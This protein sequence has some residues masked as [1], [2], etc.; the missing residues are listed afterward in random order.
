MTR[1]TCIGERRGWCER[2]HRSEKAAIQCCDRD[3]WS[4][5]RHGSR[6]DRI[7]FEVWGPTMVAVRE[8]AESLASKITS[9]WR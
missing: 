3:D 2:L 7:V 8:D 6:S 4:C 1:W 5:R 9:P